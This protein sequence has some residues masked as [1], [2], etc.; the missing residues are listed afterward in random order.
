MS[1]GWALAALGVL[2]LAWLILIGIVAGGL[3]IATATL[4]GR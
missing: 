2:G 4:V 1:P 3:V